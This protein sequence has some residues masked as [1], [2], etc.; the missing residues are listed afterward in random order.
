MAVVKI[1][2]SK[3]IKTVEMMGNVADQPYDP[4]P[5]PVVEESLTEPTGELEED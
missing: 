2:D 4:V 3:G 1:F 5:E